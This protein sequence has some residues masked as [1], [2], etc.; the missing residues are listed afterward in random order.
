MQAEH[1]SHP[2]STPGLELPQPSSLLDLAEHL[3][4]PLPGIDRAG[5]ARMADSAAI[6]RRMATG[7]DAGPI[8]SLSL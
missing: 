6:N 8:R 5:I 2:G 1:C 7:L 4:D 3:L